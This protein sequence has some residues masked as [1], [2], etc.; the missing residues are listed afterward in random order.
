MTHES[1]W[2]ATG[3]P[4]PVWHEIEAL[5]DEIAELARQDLRPREFYSRLIE[6]SVSALAARSGAVWQQVEGG[7]IELQSQVNFAGTGLADDKVALQRHSVLIAEVLQS[8]QSRLIPAK[9]AAEANDTRCNST[10]Q[11]L[12]VCP[13]RIGPGRAGLLEV[14]QRPDTSPPAQ[15]GYLEFLTS[16]A[17]LAA[18]Y[19]RNSELRRLQAN[20]S[21]WTQFERFSER[22]HESLDWEPTVYTITNEGRRLFTCD[23]MALA[24]TRGNRFRVASI[25][26]VDRLDARSAAVTKL[27]QLV[28]AVVAAGEPLQFSGDTSELPPQLQQPLAEYLDV[29]HVRSLAIVPLWQPGKDPKPGEQRF[30]LGALIVEQF[31][32]V[33]PHQSLVSRLAAVSRQCELALANC[34]EHHR[35]PLLPVW[36]AVGRVG[37]LIQ[38][39]QLPKSLLAIALISFLVAAF[40]FIP[41]DFD[42]EARGYLQPELRREI[43]A[44]SDGIVSE[45]FVADSQKVKAGELLIEL[46][47]PQLEL[48]ASRVNGELQTARKRLASILASRLS[49][50]GTENETPEKLNKLTAE[51]E[52]LKEQIAGLEQQNEVIK[53]QRAD[54]QVKSPLNGVVVTWNL[55]QLLESRPVER[56]EAL[57]TVADLNGPWQLELDV[58]D[59]YAGY[60]LAA[61]E[62]IRPDLDVSFVLATDPGVSYAAKVSEVSLSAESIEDVGPA[63]LVKASIAQGELSGVRPGASVVAKIH[64]GRRSLGFVWLHDLW[65]AIR[66]R[67]WF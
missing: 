27:E 39:R 60:L 42:I 28:A 34:A 54:L 3:Q 50:S 57:L 8:Q 18:D 58:P 24:L 9:S 45:L 4:D 16:I 64:C 66:M 40:V 15:R 52:E 23:R 61:Q 12:I 6:K 13:F 21:L 20:E 25:S 14:F 48:D 67:L 35:V 44:R 41:A 37:W 46:R 17:G 55:K 11:L 26:G 62:G 49:S 33:L 22:V 31:D 47:K 65:A 5:S 38:A 19:H 2:P 59:H 1:S 10:G 53:Q 51:E 29:G 56:G 36:R 30:A 32:S 7:P 43:F 63:I